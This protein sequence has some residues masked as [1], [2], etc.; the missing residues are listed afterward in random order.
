MTTHK[1]TRRRSRKPKSARLATVRQVKSLIRHSQEVKYMQSAQR[2]GTIDTTSYV[3]SAGWIQQINMLPQGD[4]EGQRSGDQ[5]RMQ[6]IRLNFSIINAAV[7][8]ARVRVIL[9]TFRQERTGA[10][11]TPGDILSEI[12]N[13][14]SPVSSY[15]MRNEGAYS[16]LSDKVYTVVS[17]NNTNIPIA[18]T[19]GA[20]GGYP[21]VNGSIR[22]RLKNMKVQYVGSTLTD[23]TTSGYLG[24]LYISDVPAGSPVA[25]KPQIL[26]HQT[27]K[28]TDS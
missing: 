14:L 5:I 21:C 12:G 8:F 20:V 3:D 28:Y 4:D 9:F 7:N 10:P 11:V 13:S 15:N 26:W 19:T 6:S 16:I 17:G 23:P 25:Q 1:I 24:L 22:K 27:L 18:G 2:Q